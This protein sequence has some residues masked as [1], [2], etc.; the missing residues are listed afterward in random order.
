MSTGQREWK[1]ELL[2]IFAMLLIVMTHFFA[3]DNWTVRTNPEHFRTWA[4]SAHSSLSFFGQVGVTLFV[5]ISAFFL[6]KNTSN[7]LT[8]LVKLWVQVFLY[9][10]PLYLVFLVLDWV[11]R[12]PGKYASS[13]TPRN[14]LVSFF[15]ITGIAYWFMSAFFVMIAFAPFLN[16]LMDHLSRSQSFI[17]VFL[18]I[19]VSLV[20]HILNPQSTYFTDCG[21]LISVYIIGAIIRR[22]PNSFPRIRLY[23][24][25]IVTACAY[26]VSMITTH[27]LSSK[28]ILTE[29]FKYPSNLLTAGPGASPILAVLAGTVIFIWV[30][31][32]TTTRNRQSPLVRL[33]LFLAP[34]TFGIYLLHENMLIKQVLWDAVFSYPEPA[35]FGGKVVFTLVVLPLVFVGLMLI[36]LVYSHLLVSPITNRV[37][38]MLKKRRRTGSRVI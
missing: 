22:Y 20:W 2:R 5:L 32:T 11:D 14:A 19:W 23:I 37:I 12:L 31:Q 28:N 30:S 10:M 26:C 21:Y 9:T 24:T 7:P 34:S 18:F 15:P 1:Y 38:R 17:L 3:D 35:G 13:L 8:R 27:M 36:S 6:A 16:I 33:V 4:G 29:S 25:L